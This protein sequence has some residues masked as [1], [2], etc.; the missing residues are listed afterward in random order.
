M[1]STPDIL[2]EDNHLL[3]V[4]KPF[5]IPVQQDVSNDPDLLN[6]L[7]SYIKEKDHKPGNAFVALIH[8]LDRPAGGVML[9]ARTSKAASRLGK[10][11][12]HQE[13][14]KQYLCITEGRLEKPA[15]E[16]THWL[17]KDRRRNVVTAYD[18]ERAGAK[19]A[20]LSYRVLAVN[21]DHS[22][23]RVTLHTG[24]SHQIRC[25]LSATGFPLYG[26]QKYGKRTG[27][28]QLALWA[29]KLC[30]QHPVQDKTVFLHALPPDTA[31][32]NQFDGLQRAHT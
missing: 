13:V 23:L 5:N 32:W 20:K 19:R 2:Y 28:E 29:E 15:N 10:A 17:Y 30:I 25:Q 7:K 8:R 12:Q 4:V 9:F 26:D 14:R 22:L 31:P 1:N 21:A 11:F 27:K 6:Q 3:G 24:R 16:L 18:Q